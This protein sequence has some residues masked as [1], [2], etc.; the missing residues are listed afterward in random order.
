MTVVIDASVAF[1][2][3]VPEPT[4]DRALAVLDGNAT[5][6]APDLIRI[7][8]ANAMW[9]RLRRQGEYRA[10]VMEAADA[11]PRMFDS[12]VPSA[13]VLEP[14]M[15]L[16]VELEHPLYDCLYLALAINL[17]CPVLTADKKF[18]DAA[19]AAGYGANI[20]LLR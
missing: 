5:L 2:W 14:A 15:K 7:E 11:L 17:R 6:H 19:T 18:A 16:M 4:S 8:V 13:E 9:A 20:D 3:F 10:V 12:L 1:K